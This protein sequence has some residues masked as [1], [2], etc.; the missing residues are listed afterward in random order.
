MATS[1]TVIPPEYGP[2]PSNA[3]HTGSF[4][5][6]AALTRASAGREPG[7]QVVPHLRGRGEA[8]EA[9][10]V[11]DSDD[12]VELLGDGFDPHPHLLAG[13]AG[14]QQAIAAENAGGLAAGDLA[15]AAARVGRVDEAA[16]VVD[17]YR[18]VRRALETR[19][20]NAARLQ[21]RISAPSLSGSPS[22]SASR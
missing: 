9:V 10:E 8:V 13:M 19:W 21:S 3:S 15:A 17:T 11:T 2:T 12:G 1:L 18:R 6:A 22:T 16:A 20:R 7:L 14:Q 4:G 5:N